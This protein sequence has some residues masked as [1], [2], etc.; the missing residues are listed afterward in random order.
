MLL[1]YLPN[2]VVSI[3]RYRFLQHCAKLWEN[4]AA[5]DRRSYPFDGLCIIVN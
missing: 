3:A 5:L 1:R 4:C 2:E